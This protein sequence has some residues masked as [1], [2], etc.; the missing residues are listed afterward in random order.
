MKSYLHVF[1][2]GLK[3]E[4]QSLIL[5]IT[6]LGFAFLLIAGQMTYILH[7]RLLNEND[8][9]QIRIRRVTD[10]SVPL[11]GKDRIVFYVERIKNILDIS[12]SVS[13]D[14]AEEI[15]HEL[16]TILS[17]MDNLQLHNV[18][19]AVDILKTRYES[20]RQFTNYTF[21]NE[22][23]YSNVKETDFE[24]LRYYI[25]CTGVS[26]NEAFSRQFAQMA[27]M[28][29]CIAFSIYFS[30][31]FISETNRNT[32]DT[33]RITKLSSR[34]I[35]LI[36][37]LS[38]LTACCIA[39]ALITF[40]VFILVIVFNP[41]TGAAMLGSLFHSLLVYTFPAFLVISSVS[42]M[43]F[44]LTQNCLTGLPASL[45]I[46]FLSSLTTNGNNDQ[47]LFLSPLVMSAMPYYT[48]LSQN[49]LRQLLFS[50]LAW[51]AFSVITLLIAG[52]LWEKGLSTNHKIRN[53]LF[54]ESANHTPPAAKTRN[55]FLF[56]NVKIALSPAVFLGSAA[57]LTTP[58]FLNHFTY[59][60]EA[61]PVI[62]SNVGWAAILLF[63]GLLSSEYTK[64]TYETL[65]V[66]RISR[67]KLVLTRCLIAGFTLIF[68][69]TLLYLVSMFKTTDYSA[70]M[71]AICFAQSILSFIAN[72][73]FWGT[74]SMCLSTIFRRTWFGLCVSA[75]IHLLML[76]AADTNSVLNIYFYKVYYSFAKNADLTFI[77]SS[78]IYGMISFLL[79]LFTSRIIKNPLKTKR[80]SG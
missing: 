41:G 10:V 64:D 14:E 74:F 28:M 69:E 42:V 79:V 49:Y 72:T 30:F 5:W 51:S 80:C 63:S 53:R 37:Y 8:Y 24:S 31:L 76:S 59:I 19:N 12:S 6:T 3:K 11:Y 27:A 29:S 55:S 21:W 58:L 62:L 60:T 54:S 23:I 48:P 45:I 61:G 13:D 40:L 34:K 20:L 56:Y 7:F 71:F 46:I 70:G 9:Q 50:R 36:K 26:F 57:F 38:G 39:I 33:L 75:F 68:A 52:L 66:T 73:F 78:V 16:A 1:S 35:C 17:Q 4:L 15:S 44:V 32:I 22:Y 43:L 18:M 77:A 47:N 67:L 25:E 65:Y 2:F